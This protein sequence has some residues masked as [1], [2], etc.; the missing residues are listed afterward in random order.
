LIYLFLFPATGGT[1]ERERERG[2]KGDWRGKQEDRK[3]TTKEKKV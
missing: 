1:R 3:L 2:D